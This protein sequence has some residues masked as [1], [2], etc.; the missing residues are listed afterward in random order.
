MNV[1]LSE[2]CKI[3]FRLVQLFVPRSLPKC[4]KPIIVS[5]SMDSTEAAQRKNACT[6]S[7]KRNGNSH[8]F[9][10]GMQKNQC[11]NFRWDG[12]VA[13]LSMVL[14]NAEKINLTLKKQHLPFFSVLLIILIKEGFFLFF[15][16]LLFVDTFYKEI[17]AV[18]GI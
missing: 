6:D 13:P 2:S 4:E 8:V 17:F 3:V 18:G 1:T 5:Q 14:L 15:F 7:T 11:C 16:S 12:T 9:T 10:S